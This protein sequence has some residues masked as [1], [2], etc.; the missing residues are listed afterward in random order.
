VV[1][2]ADGR[3]A[4]ETFR[5]KA[6]EIEL[7]VLDL[8]LPAIS[9]PEVLKQLRQV[10]SAIKVVLTSAYSDTMVWRA[11][12]GPRPWAYLRKPYSPSELGDLLW[13]ASEGGPR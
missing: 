2:A 5:Q 7:G 8:S 13:K 4:V 10:R 1:E 11:I 12:E 6:S 3:P 9:G